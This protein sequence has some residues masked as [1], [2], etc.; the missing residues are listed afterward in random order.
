MRR[1]RELK[2]CRSAKRHDN[3]CP[4]SFADIPSANAGQNDQIQPHWQC[5]KQNRANDNQGSGDPERLKPSIRRNDASKPHR[6]VNEWKAPEEIDGES[7]VWKEW[8]QDERNS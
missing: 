6:D 8:S 5:H 4:R 7:S 3:V 2:C 1:K